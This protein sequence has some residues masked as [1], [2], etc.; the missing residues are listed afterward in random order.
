MLSP[1]KKKKTPR[2]ETMKN[3]ERERARTKKRDRESDEDEEP[4]ERDDEEQREKQL[5]HQLRFQAMR[6]LA[7]H[8]N[9]RV[10]HH[11]SYNFSGLF[12]VFLMSYNW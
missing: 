2:T 10:L 5:L 6:I 11:C 4:C 12:W 7:Y 9:L 8:L 1:K 3:R